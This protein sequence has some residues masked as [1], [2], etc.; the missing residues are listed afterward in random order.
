MNFPSQKQY[1]SCRIGF[2][3][4]DYVIK[5]VFTSYLNRSHR[6]HTNEQFFVRRQ[7]IHQNDYG[8]ICGKYL[9]LF[10]LFDAIQS[11]EATADL[12]SPYMF[13]RVSVHLCVAILMFH[14]AAYCKIFYQF[15]SMKTAVVFIYFISSRSSTIEHIEAFVYNIEYLQK[16]FI[17]LYRRLC[18]QLLTQ[19]YFAGGFFAIFIC[20]DFGIENNRFVVTSYASNR[21]PQLISVI[22]LLIRTF[23]LIFV[24]LQHFQFLC[25]KSKFSH[26]TTRARNLTYLITLMILTS[27]AT[28]PPVSI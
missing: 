25:L 23:H 8:V 11:G 22:V 4:T 24:P 16:F 12:N 2:R 28:L 6:I 7:C 18:V 14:Y 19:S 20:Y 26:I 10:Q 13:T 27:N 5:K 3:W 9:W 21:F 15:L 1:G 17:D